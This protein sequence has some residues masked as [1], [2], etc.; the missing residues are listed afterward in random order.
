MFRQ[1]DRHWKSDRCDK[2]TFFSDVNNV[3]DLTV[4][5]LYIKDE[6]VPFA[7]ILFHY[8]KEHR[9]GRPFLWFH[10]YSNENG[11]FPTFLCFWFAFIWA[12]LFWT[13]PLHKLKESC[14]KSVLNPNHSLKIPWMRWR[15]LNCRFVL[16]LNLK[17][18]NVLSQAD[19]VKK[20]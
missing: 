18:K 3:T 1:A 12:A 15:T 10:L 6:N 4:T 9:G 11:P 7:S 20:P 13:Y 19:W 16:K 2:A 14:L 17:S 8:H 5:T